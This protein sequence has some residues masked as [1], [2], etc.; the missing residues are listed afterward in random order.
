MSV[1]ARRVSFA[2]RQEGVVLI[3]GLLVVLLAGI[4][5]LAAIRGSGMQESMAGNMRN[6]NIAFQAAESALRDGEIFVFNTSPLPAFNGVNG[7]YA[8]RPPANSV[9]LY[10]TANWADPNMVVLPA[11]NL[12]AVAAQP[13][14]VIEALN[15]DDD[16]QKFMSRSSTE[17]GSIDLSADYFRITARGVGLTNDSVVI[18]QSTVRLGR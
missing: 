12:S 9:L 11:L 8:E 7:L 13:A 1:F 10:T 4:L 16:K 14:Y 5:S 2:S 18:L 3:V 17:A 15:S 6:Y